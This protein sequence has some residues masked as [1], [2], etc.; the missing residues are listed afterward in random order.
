MFYKIIGIW[1]GES[2]SWP[3]TQEQITLNNIHYK[4]LRGYVISNTG[5]LSILHIG[6]K[7][8]VI[9]YEID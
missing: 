2:L 1:H 5:I 8:G 7:F 6:E 3:R 9:E 4:M